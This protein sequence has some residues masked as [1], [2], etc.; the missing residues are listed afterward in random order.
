MQVELAEDD[1]SVA[2]EARDDVG[3]FSGDAVFEHGA[4]RSGAGAGGV[5]VV[6][7]GDGDA[8]ERAAELSGFCFRVQHGGL[9]EG[10]LRHDGDVGVDFGVIDR[11]AGEQGW[12]S[13]VEVTVRAW[14]PGGGFGE[15]ESGE[16][17]VGRGVGRMR[18]QEPKA[19]TAADAPRSREKVAA[20]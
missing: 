15:R 9:G 7:E 19:A 2:L 16:G 3:V 12:V 10:L 18:G 6:L 5:D 13:S 4:G 14:M 8:V 20:G 1:G 17:L 11:D